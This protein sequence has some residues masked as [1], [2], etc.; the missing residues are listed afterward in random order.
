M[1]IKGR[2]KKKRSQLNILIQK[3]LK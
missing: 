1:A 3:V 2:R